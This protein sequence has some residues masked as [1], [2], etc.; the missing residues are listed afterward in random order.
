MLKTTCQKCRMREGERFGA[1]VV[2]M[3]GCW[4]DLKEACYRD[5]ELICEVGSHVEYEL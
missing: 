2:D 4:L 3:H 5:N 1:C